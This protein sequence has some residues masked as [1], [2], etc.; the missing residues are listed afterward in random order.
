MGAVLG[1]G[2]GEEPVAR[3]CKFTSLLPLIFLS[4]FFILAIFIMVAFDNIYIFI[5]KVSSVPLHLS[6]SFFS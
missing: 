3:F 1:A 5:F 2:G 4:A 6:V